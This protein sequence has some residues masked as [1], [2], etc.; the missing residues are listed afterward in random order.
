MRRIRVGYAL[1]VALLLA[2]CP[3]GDS[4]RAA[5]D[6]QPGDTARVGT[7]AAV[8]PAGQTFA[9]EEFA[10]SGVSGEVQ[11]MPREGEVE[12]RVSVEG[13]R[14]NAVVP[15][16]LHTG[17][18]QAPGPEVADLGDLATDATG[19]GQT[20]STVGLPP[21]Q[22]LNGMHILA[23]HLEGGETPIPIA[24]SRVPEYRGGGATAPGP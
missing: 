10:G 21:Q 11:A 23:A 15:I 8:D 7:G 17:S 19:R 24:C 5:T 18:C 13:A 2:G 6:A 1:G 16:S 9:L 4:D 22:V 3:D 12:L 20:Q 14:P